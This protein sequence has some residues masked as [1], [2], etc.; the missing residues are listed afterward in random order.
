[1]VLESL[2]RLDPPRP[3]GKM[4]L[5][6]RLGEGGM[7]SVYLAGIGQGTL[8]RMT[9]VKLLRADVADADY[10]SRFLDEANIVV[11]LHHNNL[12]DVR[13]AGELDGQLYIAMELVEGRDLADVWDRC[14]DVG[15]AFPVPLAVYLVREVLRG[16]HYAHTFPGLGLVHRDVSPSN[17]LVDWAGAVRL[18]DFGLATSTL[19]ATT[20]VPGLVYGKVGYM[21]PEQAL[22][23][24]LDGRAD[25]YSCGVVLWELVT[26]RPL[27]SAQVDTR[28]VARFAARPAGELSRRVDHDLESIIS[29]ALANRREDRY[30]TAQSFMIALSEWLAQKAPTTTQETLAEFMGDL[31]GN[32]HEEDRRLYQSLLEAGIPRDEPIAVGPIDDIVG[33]SKSAKAPAG[34]V[35]EAIPPGTVIA[36]RYRVE[37]RIGRGGMGVVYLGQHLT[38][39]R[40]VAIK[41]LTHEW[42]SNPVVARRFRE[43][44]RAAS[45]VGHGN[46]VEV[47]DAGTLDD[48]RLYIV[49]EYLTGN[50]L[51]QEIENNGPLT[52]ERALAIAREV[53]RAIMAAHAVG[54]IH[55]D[56]KP[57][58]VML[59]PQLD[60]ELVKVL[61]FGIA[62]S[63]ERLDLERRLTRPGRCLGTPEYMAP[64]Q[65]RGHEP[66]PLFDIYAIGVMIYEALVGEPP[67]LSENLAD[68]IKRKSNV[69]AP[70]VREVRSDAPPALCTLIAQCLE[71]EPEKRPASAAEV[72]ERLNAISDGLFGRQMSISMIGPTIDDASGDDEDAG[73]SLSLSARPRASRPL[74]REGRAVS[75]A[76]PAQH[77]R[78]MIFGGLGSVFAMMLAGGLWWSWQ[79]A[80]EGQEGSMAVQVRP[81]AA[82]TSPREAALATSKKEHEEPAPAESVPPPELQAGPE[83][84]V[85][86]VVSEEP[87][88]AAKPRPAATPAPSCKQQREKAASAFSGHRYKETLQALSRSN[89]WSKTERQDYELMLVKSY[90]ETKKLEQ[91]A[92]V[93][94]KSTYASVKRFIALCS[95]RGSS[96]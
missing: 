50:T 40:K 5:L 74:G 67:F 33:P 12:V 96:G 30:P 9:A 89:C 41:V 72:L 87:A 14:A 49:M 4:R 91:C 23:V 36:D 81:A 58:N 24:P 51:F 57:D 73:E 43:E 11:R 7:A 8:A 47:F 70:R 85:V 29:R 76:L 93:A 77:R 15:R 1:M 32:A 26:G 64:E 71:I 42:S 2:Q 18:A 3:L 20:T 82:D 59:V 63:T 54:I 61:D 48:G 25:A 16:L 66:T 62:A 37:R 22:R 17:I 46:I 90:F 69:T 13:E 44:A 75:D 55:R 94:R 92:E 79:P 10:R 78:K 83:E 80:R 19:K 21:A 86:V 38:V 95:G 52:L 39:G 45:A 65:A 31:F 60:G 53:T 84:E 35:Q 34:P 56:L 68:V 28:T 88:A 6:A 27:R